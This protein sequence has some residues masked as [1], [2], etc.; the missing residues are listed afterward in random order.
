[1]PT[2]ATLS[3]GINNHDGSWTLTPA[4]LASLSVTP[5]SSTDAFTLTVDAT[6]T[7][8]T[9]TA[10]TIGTIHVAVTPVADK[11]TLTVADASGLEDTPIALSISRR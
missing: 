10:D 11:P 2:D 5:G 8:G 7:D 4:Q 3:A 6:A 9:S 1:M